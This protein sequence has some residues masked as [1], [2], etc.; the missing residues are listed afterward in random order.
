[1][2]LPLEAKVFI[3]F[4]LFLITFS[5]ALDLSIN[6]FVEIIKKPRKIIFGVFAQTILLPIFSFLFIQLADLSFEYAMAIIF[7]AACPGGSSSNFISY[8]AGGSV[9]Y[10]MS[11]TFFS[12][13]IAIISTPFHMTFWPTFLNSTQL[14]SNLEVNRLNLFISLL[15][16]LII[17]LALGILAKSY[18]ETRVKFLKNTLKKL[19]M[20]FMISIFS[21]AIYLNLNSLSSN[22]K[23]IFILVLIHQSIA[24]SIGYIMSTLIKLDHKESR[25]LT[26][27]VGYQNTSL[28]LGVALAFYSD[29]SQLILLIGWWTIWHNISALLLISAWRSK[30]YIKEKAY[31]T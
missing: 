29:M 21:Y 10:S 30:D 1:M 9:A 24:L 19:S 14:V 25:S 5:L 8:L 13:I 20:F 6:N 17:P 27:E 15:I 12:S 3:G 31:T 22:F 23:T 4:A 26:I 7:I 28:A 18:F 2:Q 16:L 11:L